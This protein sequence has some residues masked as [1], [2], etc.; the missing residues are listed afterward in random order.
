MLSSEFRGPVR[1]GAGITWDSLS[2]PDGLDV[3]ILRRP[4]YFQSGR[5]TVLGV[6][7]ICE[8]RSTELA[9]IE[10][11]VATSPRSATPSSLSRPEF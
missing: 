6:T 2:R 5:C 11:A 4:L 10:R 1:G 9:E 7:V 8:I 3:R